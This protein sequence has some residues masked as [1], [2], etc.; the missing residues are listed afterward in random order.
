M[1]VN[2][3]GKYDQ[4]LRDY[5]KGTFLNSSKSGQLLPGLAANTPEQRESQKRIFDKVWSS[6]ERIMG[7]MRTRM[8][9]SLRDPSRTVEE[10]EKTIEILI[11]L[12]G[13]DEPAWVYL[14]SQH[15]HIVDGLKGIYNKAQ[16]K[17]KCMSRRWRSAV[18][19]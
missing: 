7:D 1:K 18:L 3:Q 4:A 9:A 16:D 8:D 12:A 19:S 5:K 17:C 11:E 15:A 14:D 6:V 10:Q 2:P 13:D